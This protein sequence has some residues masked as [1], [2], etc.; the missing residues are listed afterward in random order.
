MS[1][2]YNLYLLAAALPI[3]KNCMVPKENHMGSFPANYCVKMIGISSKLTKK[4]NT[5]CVLENIV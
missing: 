1:N 2:V 5:K 3:T 4:K